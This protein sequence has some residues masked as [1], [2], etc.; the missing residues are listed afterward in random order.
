MLPI[1]QFTIAQGLMAYLNFQFFKGALSLFPTTVL[2]LYLN[3]SSCAFQTVRL[4]KYQ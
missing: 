1:L 2:S 3:V 4:K